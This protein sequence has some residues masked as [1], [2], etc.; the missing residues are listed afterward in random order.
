M[1]FP[2][3]IQVSEISSFAVAVLNKHEGILRQYFFNPLLPEI[4]KLQC[5]ESLEDRTKHK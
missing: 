2:L 1:I 3:V 4:I 5:C